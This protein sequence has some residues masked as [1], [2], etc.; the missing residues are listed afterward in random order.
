V[1]EDNDIDRKCSPHRRSTAVGGTPV[2]RN[3]MAAAAATA[4]VRR[5]AH[6][7]RM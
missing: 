3:D 1:K 6:G 4:T 2:L 7:T 5:S